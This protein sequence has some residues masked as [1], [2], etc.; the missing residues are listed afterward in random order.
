[1]ADYTM[2]E[3]DLLRRVIGRDKASEMAEQKSRFDKRA[4]RNKIDSEK[5]AHIFELMVKFCRYSFS[6]SHSAAYAMVS[7]QTGFI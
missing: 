6:K 7:Y 5:A 2:G 1:M 3:A 4:A